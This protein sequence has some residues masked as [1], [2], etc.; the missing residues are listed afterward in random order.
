MME[1]YFYYSQKQKDVCYSMGNRWDNYCKLD[2]GD[3]KLYSEM[4]TENTGSNWDD[5]VFLGH[6]I[7]HSHE[8]AV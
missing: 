1:G 4:Q 8:E 5:A 3:I 2:N 6:G 7:W